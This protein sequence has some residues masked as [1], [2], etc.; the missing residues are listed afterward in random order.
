MDI[1]SVLQYSRHTTIELLKVLGVTVDQ[2][3]ET[4][5]LQ[6]LLYRVRLERL[7]AGID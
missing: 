2:D 4:K 6:L 7:V 5:S 3:E 1:S